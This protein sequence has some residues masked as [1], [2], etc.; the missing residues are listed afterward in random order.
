MFKCQFNRPMRIP[1]GNHRAGAVMYLQCRK[2]LKEYSVR[3]RFSQIRVSGVWLLRIRHVL[4]STNFHSNN[5]DDK[6]FPTNNGALLKTKKL[7][8]RAILDRVKGVLR[9]AMQI[10]LVNTFKANGVEYGEKGLAV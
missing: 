1:F 3:L 9:C 5:G 4:E 10:F 6:Q 7:L 2:K 8:V